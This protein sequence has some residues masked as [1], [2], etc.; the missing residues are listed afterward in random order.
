M[1]FGI[2]IAFLLALVLIIW[3]ISKYVRVGFFRKSEKRE[4]TSS[5]ELEDE[6]QPSLQPEKEERP[7]ELEEAVE[8]ADSEEAMRMYYDD[9]GEVEHA[10]PEVEYEHEYEYE[11]SGEEDTYAESADP[12]YENELSPPASKTD[13]IKI[14]REPKFNLFEEFDSGGTAPETSSIFGDVPNIVKKPVSYSEEPLGFQPEFNFDQ[15][16]PKYQNS[17]DRVIDMIA[18]FPKS[19]DNFRRTDLLRLYRNLKNPVERPHAVMGL[20]LETGAWIN[21]HSKHAPPVYS[22]LI[23]TMQLVYKG[24]P[25]SEEDWWR[26]I[27]M[28]EHYSE[29]LRRDF[30]LSSSFENVLEESKKLSGEVKHLD[31]LAVLILKAEH[32]IVFSSQGASYLAREFGFKQQQGRYV[33][34]KIEDISGTPRY[35]F[36]VVPTIEENKEITRDIGV[37]PNLNALIL[38]S[39]LNCVN[40]PEYAFK[41]MVDTAHDLQDR[42]SV[43]LVDHNYVPI[44][45]EALGRINDYIL[46]FVQNMK[47]SG[48]TPGS[49]VSTRLFGSSYEHT[50]PFVDSDSS[51]F[52]I[53]R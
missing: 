13:E 18:W 28:V 27:Q 36:S 21:V 9:D 1:E 25:V 2:L 46:E 34:D 40:D 45:S 16:F 32:G 47:N 15:E 52:R 38:C 5:T 49:E 53:E 11:Y 43:R 37:S 42:I 19:T 7:A 24:K 14:G 8:L 12:E 29:K 44:E 50:T 30:C 39:N 48:F 41:A 17:D 6:K 3:L 10:Q 23:L 51:F 35:L 20:S 4:V 31:L 26:F 33:Y 22:D